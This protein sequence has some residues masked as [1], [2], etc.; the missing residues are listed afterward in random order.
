LIDTSGDSLLA[1][2]VSACT[3]CGGASILI[4]GKCRRLGDQHDGFC[5]D[6]RRLL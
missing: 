1:G 3:I 6:T 4:A 2:V 5:N